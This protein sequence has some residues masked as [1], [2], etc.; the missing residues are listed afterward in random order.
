MISAADQAEREIRFSEIINAKSAERNNYL[1]KLIGQ[2]IDDKNFEKVS[3]VIKILIVNGCSP[4]LLNADKVTPF[5]EL[6]T[7]RIDPVLKKDLITFMLNTSYVNLS[8]CNQNDVALS[9]CDYGEKE[10]KIDTIQIDDSDFMLQQLI[11][12]NEDDF[13]KSFENVERGAYELSPLL[14]IAVAKNL[15]RSVKFLIKSGVD[16]NELSKENKF[17]KE[18]AFLA[19]SLGRIKI[20]ELLLSQPELN[21]KS[22]KGNKNLLHEILSSRNINTDEVGLKN[23]DCHGST[24]HNRLDQL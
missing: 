20:F 19:A 17:G 10:A 2:V 15:Y 4:N 12:E 16:V 13:I 23:L 1:H 9:L 22:T 18:P 11:D 21:F 14:E 6:I 5:H 24:L 7:R 3:K 8:L